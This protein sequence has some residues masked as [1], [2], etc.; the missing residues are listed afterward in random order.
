MVMA[1]KVNNKTKKSAPFLVKVNPDI[2]KKVKEFLEPTGAQIGKFYD[3][4]ALEK[5]ERENKLSPLKA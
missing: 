5:L 1:V 4:A 2:L 3:N